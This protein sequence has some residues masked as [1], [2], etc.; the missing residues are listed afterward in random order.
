MSDNHCRKHIDNPIYVDMRTLF[1]FV[2]EQ[3]GR[4]PSDKVDRWTPW[5][6]GVLGTAMG[7]IMLWA[8]WTGTR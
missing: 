3:M 2:G 7:G 1:E 5:I 6:I 8:W 4:T